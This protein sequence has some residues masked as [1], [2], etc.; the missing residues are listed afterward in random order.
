MFCKNMLTLL[1]K[2]I[3]TGWLNFIRNSAISIATCFI[4]GMTIFLITSLLIMK[5]VA[6]YLINVIQ[7]K[8]DISIYLKDTVA[9]EEILV[10]KDEIA[11]IPE[12]KEV[13]YVSRVEALDRFVERYKNN[14]V[15]IESLAEVGNPLLPAL[16][17]KAWQANQYDAVVSFLENS[18]SKDL[19]DKVDYHERKPVI[20][21]IS[22]MTATFN[23]LGIIMSLVLAI[24][25]I[26]VAFNQVR[27]AIYNAREEIAIQRLVGASNWFIRGP[28]LA[29]GA[30]S[31]VFAAVG[32][33]LIFSIAIFILS[34]KL[35]VLFSGL[36]I[37]GVFLS[38]FWLLFFIQLLVGIGLGVIS[39]II[40]MK[41]HLEV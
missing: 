11:K 4:I 32:A 1:K 39:S 5:D 12:V 25:A 7:E 35:T 37:S 3:K 10:L 31:G 33:A 21:R 20:D 40:A 27:L 16:N 13:Q 30:I 41:K 36:S 34:P 15:V 26:L 29:Q 28:F 19:I 23:A 18:P 9:E 22:A 24:V 6:D 17:V 38:K 2:T 8:V 14:P